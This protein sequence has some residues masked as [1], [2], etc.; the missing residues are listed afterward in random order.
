MFTVGNVACAFLRLARF[1]FARLRFLF[2]LPLLRPAALG[3][4]FGRG[5]GAG[6]RAL[7]GC[8]HCHRTFYAT[9][10]KFNFRIF[11]NHGVVI[12]RPLDVVALPGSSA[13][14]S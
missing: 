3:R 4:C 14:P 10:L 2:F 8:H 11:R 12:H 9:P 5:G 7:P 13:C 6:G 1:F